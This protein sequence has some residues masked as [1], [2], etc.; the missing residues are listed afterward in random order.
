M[1]IVVKSE[2]RNIRLY[3]PMFVITSGIRLSKYIMKHVDV[4]D[5][6]NNAIKYIDCI[7]TKVLLTAINELK[8]FKGLTLVEVKASNGDHVLIKI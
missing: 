3:V 8:K 7:D 2:G 6:M 5:D 4:D 1:K